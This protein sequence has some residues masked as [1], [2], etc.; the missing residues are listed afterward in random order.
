MPKPLGAIGTDDMDL[1]SSMKNVLDKMHVD[2]FNDGSPT[3]PAQKQ[4]QPISE[5][6]ITT[7]SLKEVAPAATSVTPAPQPPPV[8]APKPE[9]KTEKLI[10]PTIVPPK[11]VPKPEVK[12]E[13]PVQPKVEPAKSIKPDVQATKDSRIK[14]ELIRALLKNTKFELV[15]ISEK[16]IYFKFKDNVFKISPK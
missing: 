3:H 14:S 7:K 11:V 8:V 12:I 10:Q 15:N 1:A 5:P 4:A 6:T 16:E 13:K 9:I 2:G